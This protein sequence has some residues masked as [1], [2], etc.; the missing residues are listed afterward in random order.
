MI[1]GLRDLLIQ[2][3]VSLCAGAVL[4]GYTSRWDYALAVTALLLL[5]GAFVFVL[6]GRISFRKVGIAQWFPQRGKSRS[7][8]RCLETC[9]ESVDF[10]ATW[11]GS[12]PSLSTDIEG[13]F[14]ELVRKG[15]KFRFL[16]LMPGSKGELTRRNSRLRWPLGQ[17]QTDIRWL[18]S[19]KEDL[20][21]F[22]DNFRLALYEETPVWA[23]VI[24]DNK[25]AIVGFYG[26]GTGRDNP[27]LLLRSD[28]KL[29]T[30]LEAFR[31]HYERVW[32]SATEI[33]SLT[34]FEH[35]LQGHPSLRTGGFVLAITGPS[36][37]GKTSLCRHLVENNIASGSTTVTTRHPRPNEVE[38]DQ[39]EYVNTDE[40]RKLSDAGQLLCETDF[41]GNWYGITT[42]MVYGVINRGV[43]LA[44]DTIIPP[45]LLK[46]RLGKSVVIVFVSPTSGDTLLERIRELFGD[47]G[48]SRMLREENARHQCRHEARHC[49]YYLRTD[50]TVESAGTQLIQMAR[51]LSESYKKDGNLFPECLKGFRMETAIE[52]G[53]I[54]IFERF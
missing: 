54:D 21:T 6:D 50:S 13:K 42:Q 9:S 20:G 45:R 31:L 41:C 46:A 16:L 24:I 10:L 11:G 4:W 7:F 14:E 19:I 15:C 43:I 51:E 1:P 2:F 23:V 34:E 44:L 53:G 5:G 22:S 27:G 38:S 33:S 17:P 8:R 26:K 40:F 28:V 3:A 36:T 32:D 39:Y 37:G 49:D 52:H 12:I 29:P 18:L 25:E 47:D 48:E 35:L 30:F